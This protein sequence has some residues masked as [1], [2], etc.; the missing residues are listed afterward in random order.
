MGPVEHLALQKHKQSFVIAFSV[1]DKH[2]CILNLLSLLPAR[3][4]QGEG[5]L[6]QSRHEGPSEPRGEPIQGAGGIE[7]SGGRIH[8]HQCAQRA[9]VRKQ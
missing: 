1:L 5:S 7:E 9:D 6:L 4:C 3:A 8:H 2:G